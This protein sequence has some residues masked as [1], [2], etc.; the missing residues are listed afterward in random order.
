MYAKHGYIWNLATCSWE[1]GASI[2]EDPVITCDEI[3]DA[4]AR[5]TTNKQKQFQ[6]YLMKIIQPL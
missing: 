6:Q 5:T 2:T 1:S 3:I 4:E